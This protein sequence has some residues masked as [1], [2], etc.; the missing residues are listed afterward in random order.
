EKRGFSATVQVGQFV[1]SEVELS[2]LWKCDRKTVSRV[3]DQM[4]QVGLIST[5]QTNRTS[6]HTL[7]CVGSW[8]FDGVTVKNSFFKRLS[9]R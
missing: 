1:A 2:H 4:N 7:P 8:I 5:V 9:E 3:L 6:I